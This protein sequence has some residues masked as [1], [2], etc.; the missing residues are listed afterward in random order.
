MSE[1]PVGTDHN[2]WFQQVITVKSDNADM[3]LRRYP[4]QHSIETRQKAREGIVEGTKKEGWTSCPP[5]FLNPAD[6]LYGILLFDLSGIDG[7]F[8]P[9]LLETRLSLNSTRLTRTI[10][11]RPA[12]PIELVVDGI[13]SRIGG[14]LQTPITPR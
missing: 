5:L 9:P 4:T 14:D 6:L 11:R 1:L 7:I 12:G 10:R 13:P 8:I 2:L 3:G